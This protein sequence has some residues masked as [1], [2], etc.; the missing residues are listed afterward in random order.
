MDFSHE[1]EF[2]DN[3]KIE[4]NALIDTASSRVPFLRYEYLRTWWQTRGGGEWDEKVQLILIYARE[5][6]QLVGIAPCFISEHQGKKVLLFLG[7]IEISDYLDF[8]VKPQLLPAFTQG[9][10]TYVRS[11]L[12]SEM[13]I[14]G[15]DLYNLSDQS[16]TIHALQ[17]ASINLGLTCTV[18]PI[19]R[20]PYIPL[21]G[22]YEEYMA[23]LDKKQRHEMRRKLRRMLELPVPTEWYIANDPAKINDEIQDFI[24]LMDLDSEK[25]AFLTPIMREQMQLS[26]QEAFNAGILQ[27]AFMRIG[28]E[29]TAAYV[30]FDFQNR[31]FVYN[32]GID[33]RFFEH[34]PGWVLLTHLIKWAN[35]N[36]RFEFDFMRG[37]EDYK[38]KFG[39]VDRQVMRV[40]IDL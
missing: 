14:Q 29:K 38:Y 9:L 16:P 22:N 13:G 30:N 11:T 1:N 18:N 7:C 5:N 35:E 12:A 28:N 32:S 17:N 4:W 15:I 24:Q 25:H 37:T 20:S 34:S 3:L 21:S 8:L 40:T 23:G 33:P 36:D 19:T 6:G 26:L 2:N 39:A 31:I 10:L 27:L